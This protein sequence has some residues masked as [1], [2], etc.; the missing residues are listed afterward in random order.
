MQFFSVL[1]QHTQ[2]L[3]KIQAYI[4]FLEGTDEIYSWLLFIYL[5]IFRIWIVLHHGLQTV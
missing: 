5:F 2:T 4:F 3:K 1:F